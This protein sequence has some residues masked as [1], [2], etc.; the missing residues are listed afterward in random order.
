MPCDENFIPFI[1]EE[2]MRAPGCHRFEAFYGFFFSAAA[3]ASLNSA[4]ASI[5]GG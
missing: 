4:T 3:T 5:L 1:L 2:G